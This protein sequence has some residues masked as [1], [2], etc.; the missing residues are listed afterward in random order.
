MK[1]W[2]LVALNAKYSHT[3]LSVRSICA[4]VKKYGFN[5]SF[6]ELTVNDGYFSILENIM[7]KSPEVIGFSVYIWNVELIKRLVFD[8]K[9]IAPKTKIFLGGPEVSYNKNLFKE[10][11]LIDFVI[12]GEGEIP[13]LKLLRGEKNIPGVCF[14]D[15]DF[16][17][18]EIEDMDNIPFVYENELE[19]LKNR[20]VYY[21]TSRGCPFRCAFCISSL[22]EGV[23]TLPLARVFSEIDRFTDAKIKRVK[24]VDRTFNFDKKRAK[25]IIKYILSKKRETC[26]HFEIGADLLDDE[27]IE[28]LNTAPFDS[29]Q[30]EAGIQSTNPDAL[31]LCNRATDMEKLKGNL[32]KLKESKIRIHLDLIA[33]LPKEDFESFKNSFNEAYGMAPK[34]LQVGFLKLLH[35]SSLREEK[36]KYNYKFLNIAPYEVLSN[37]FISFFELMQIK[38]VDNSVD[39]YLNSGIFKNSLKY[40]FLNKEITPFDF[41]L[42]LGEKM[43]DAKLSVKDKFRL[44]SEFYKDDNEFLEYLKLDYV[45][46]ERG[47]IPE[48][49]NN[50]KT[51]ENLSLVNEFLRE[52]GAEAL[53]L[54]D[55]YNNFIK[56]IDFEI[57]EFNGVKSLYLFNRKTNEI[58]I[59]ENI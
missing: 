56:Y 24:L 20:A 51:K 19:K 18:S 3:S 52:K 9:S 46:K 58:I 22:T 5:L 15:S 47:A 43:G 59:K 49:F 25:E 12:R 44:L 31:R 54:N 14:S 13:V 1:N 39:A 57:F 28:I 21:E 2:L 36:E 30:L 11:P 16:T 17:F 50:F 29:I 23:R 35:G 42:S 40:I 10:I 45:T 6:A 8:I 34:V 33:G 4:Y 37:D 7:K 27:L 26:F 48:F 32:L 41:Y 55:K 53:K 38:K